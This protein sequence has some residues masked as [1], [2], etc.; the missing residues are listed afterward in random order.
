[1]ENAPI[2][3]TDSFIHSCSTQMRRSCTTPND[4]GTP[5]SRL[6]APPKKAS[7]L[8]PLRACERRHPIP[9]PGRNRPLVLL[10][11]YNR[12]PIC[13]LTKLHTLYG[14]GINASKKSPA[15][16]ATHCRCRVSSAIVSFCGATTPFRCRLVE[17]FHFPL[18]LHWQDL[19]TE[20]CR[21]CRPSR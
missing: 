14:Y 12:P 7:L 9:I 11:N 4:L 2:H 1:M 19:S 18:F 17:P 20:W 6:S 13:R 16:E 15:L 21:R 5:P 3:K 10:D 8:S